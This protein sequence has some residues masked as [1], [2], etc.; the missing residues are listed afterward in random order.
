MAANECI[1]Y[2]EPGAAITAKAEAAVTGKRFVMITDPAEADFNALD[3]TASGGSI[4]CSHATAAGLAIGVASYDAAIG[5]EFYVLAQPGLVLPVTADGAITAGNQVEVG[6]TGKAKAQD[7]GRAV[8]VAL[9]TVADGEDCPVL[10]Y[11]HGNP[12][13]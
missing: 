8:G 11:G 1:P 2:F 4:V 5:G 3:D 7:A 10:F 6:A 12:A 13:E 9:D